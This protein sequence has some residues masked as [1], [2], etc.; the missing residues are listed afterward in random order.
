MN[1]TYESNDLYTDNN[2]KEYKVYPMLLKDFPTVSTYLQK[3]DLSNGLNTDEILSEPMENL[4]AILRLALRDTYTDEE[5]LEIDIGTA[6][7]ILLK[8]FGIVK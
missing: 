5:M 6:H 3:L 2:C 4:I 7:E 8:F 1:N